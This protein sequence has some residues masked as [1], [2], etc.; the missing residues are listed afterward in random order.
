MSVPS[1]AHNAMPRTALSVA[2]VTMNGWGTRPHTKTAPLTKPTTT[3]VASIATI[4]TPAGWPSWKISAPTTEREGDRRADGEVDPT[5]HDGE[6][7]T[8]RQYRDDRGLR[9]DVPEVVARAEHGGRRRDDDQEEDENQ[10]RPGAEGQQRGLQQ[11][12][13]SVG[14]CPT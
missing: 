8:E 12:V 9:E 5:R 6:E 13:A 7:L 4:T 14:R 10:Q 2:S 11:P 1:E 3:P